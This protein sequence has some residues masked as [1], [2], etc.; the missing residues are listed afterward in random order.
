MSIVWTKSRDLCFMILMSLVGILAVTA[1]SEESKVVDH[2]LRIMFA[3]NV[4]DVSKSVVLA[5]TFSWFALGLF[6]PIW[7]VRRRNQAS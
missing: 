4:S 2:P 6:V 3:W 5:Q 7:V 1:L